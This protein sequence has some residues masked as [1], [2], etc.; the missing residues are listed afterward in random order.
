MQENDLK[1]ILSSI[2]ELG[3][4]DETSADVAFLINRNNEELIDKTNGLGRIKTHL[5][6]KFELIF[7]LPIELKSKEH[8]S[9]RCFN[10]GRVI[11]FPCWLLKKEMVK[12]KFYWFLCKGNDKV[13]LNNC[14]G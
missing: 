10:C 3:S 9:I 6:R 8:L 2:E 12:N 11:D 13:S 14:R 7:S 4:V 5:V 1:S